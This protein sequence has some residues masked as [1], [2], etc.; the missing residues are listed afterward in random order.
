[1]VPFSYGGEISV[2]RARRLPAPSVYRREKAFTSGPGGD[3]LQYGPD[4]TAGHE[5]WA[6]GRLMIE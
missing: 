6:P 5:R 3:M 2:I 4:Q 1:M